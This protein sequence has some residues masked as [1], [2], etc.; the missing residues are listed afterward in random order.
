MTKLS[1]FLLIILATLSQAATR[2]A[3]TAT[4]AELNNCINGTSCNGLSTT[5][6]TDGDV[7]NVP[8]SV[9]PTGGTFTLSIAGQTTSA[10]LGFDATATQIQSALEALPS[11]GTGNVVVTNAR[12]GVG[13]LVHFTGTKALQPVVMTSTSNLIP[14]AL[15]RAVVTRSIIGTATKDERDTLVLGNC[16]T[17]TDTS[18]AIRKNITI[19]G[20]GI[21]N[22]GPKTSIPVAFRPFVITTTGSDSTFTMANIEFLI[23]HDDTNGNAN[24]EILVLGGISRTHYNNTGN[25]VG[26]VR[27]H[28]LRFTPTCLDTNMAFCLRTTDWVTGVMD[29]CWF[30]WPNPTENPN[31]TAQ[32]F[33]LI[34]MEH[35]SAPGEVCSSTPDFTGG[36]PQFGHRSWYI[37]YVPGG[38]FPNT[39]AFAAGNYDAFYLEDNFIMKDQFVYD[40]PAGAPGIISGGGRS[41]IRHNSFTGM[42]SMHGFGETGAVAGQRVEECYN[43]YGKQPYATTGQNNA[44]ANRGGL[45]FFYNERLEH[46]PNVPP[47]GI[48][49]ARLC[50]PNGNMNGPADATNFFDD[51]HRGVL[52]ISGYPWRPNGTFTPIREPSDTRVGSVYFQGNQSLVKRGGSVDG[53]GN[54]H[55]DQFLLVGFDPKIGRASCRERV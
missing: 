50:A 10:V 37:P 5:P 27:L 3:A 48:Q 42:L 23:I 49:V 8:V 54:Q 44:H 16:W 15:N 11:V 12:G 13:F 40:S 24:P 45:L 2:T 47:G 14:A 38:G 1:T 46:F 20:V 39:P 53:L 51:N 9:V 32:N 6:M 52:T 4:R 33:A 28:H 26:G 18:I 7:L 29:H 25:I 43:N 19:Q 35:A 36:K 21:Y 34:G 41:V 30:D 22:S 55:G 31:G 17:S